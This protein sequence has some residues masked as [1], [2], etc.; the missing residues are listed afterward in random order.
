[1]IS[2][3]LESVLRPVSSRSA[4]L[5]GWGHPLLADLPA[6]T[7]SNPRHE[8]SPSAATGVDGFASSADFIPDPFPCAFEIDMRERERFDPCLSAQMAMGIS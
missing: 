8:P 7:L 4:T 5:A 1:M 3:H 2:F 6:S